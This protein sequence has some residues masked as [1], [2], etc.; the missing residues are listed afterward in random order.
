MSSIVDLVLNH[1]IRPVLGVQCGPASTL[2]RGH[3]DQARPARWRSRGSRPLD[4]TAL[5][6]RRPEVAVLAGGSLRAGGSVQRESLPTPDGS[7][8]TRAWRGALAALAASIPA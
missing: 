8:R 2:H 4:P 1:L 5:D 7:A 3:G 6:G